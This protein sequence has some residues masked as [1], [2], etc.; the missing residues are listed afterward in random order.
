MDTVDNAAPV[1]DGAVIDTG[2]DIM[3]GPDAVGGDVPPV[4]TSDPAADEIAVL[5]AERDAAL[6]QRD[7]WENAATETKALLDTVTA[8][9]DALQARLDKAAAAPKVTRVPAPAKRRA[10]GEMKDDNP[11]A[12]DLL[13]LIGA[14]EVV[15]VVFSDGKREFTEIAPLLVAGDVWAKVIGGLALR[16][17]ELTVQAPQDGG[18]PLKGYALLLDGKQ[19]AWAPRPETLI[20]GGGRQFNLRD[21]VLFPAA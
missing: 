16:V 7:Y 10:A 9:R 20:L 4:P 14:A 15:E 1:V 18:L 17:P 19:V 8:E 11:A 6:E 13:A 2:T 3:S 12:D 21:D 5:T